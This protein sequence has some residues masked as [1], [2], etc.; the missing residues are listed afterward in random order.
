MVDNVFVLHEVII[1]VFHE[2]ICIPKIEKLSFNIAHVRI[3]GP[4]E[5]DKTINDSF[6]DN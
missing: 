4:V 2:K 5:C 1:D 6:H 3:I